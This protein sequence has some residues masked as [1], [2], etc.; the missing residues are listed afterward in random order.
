M[1]DIKICLMFGYKLPLIVS[2]AAKICTA[3]MQFTVTI[4]KGN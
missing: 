3:D 2:R 4:W 1:L